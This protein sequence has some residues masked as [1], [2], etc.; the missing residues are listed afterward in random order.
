MSDKLFLTNEAAGRREITQSTI[1]KYTISGYSS[2]KSSYVRVTSRAVRSV[3]THSFTLMRVIVYILVWV[4]QAREVGGEVVGGNFQ[5]L[6][7]AEH[8]LQTAM[9]HDSTHH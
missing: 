9:H 7:L 5:S 2:H 4:R 8:C 6:H 3:P 1:S